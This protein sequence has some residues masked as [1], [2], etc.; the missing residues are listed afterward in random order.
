MGDPKSPHFAR[1]FLS[2]KIEMKK[3]KEK[4]NENEVNILFGYFIPERT[5]L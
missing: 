1:C 4:K 5:L 2:G 3:K